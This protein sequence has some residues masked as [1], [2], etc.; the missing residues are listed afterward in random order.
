MTSTWPPW[1][2]WGAVDT[3]E[4]VTDS[5]GLCF[6]HYLRDPGNTLQPMLTLPAW[7]QEELRGTTHNH[8]H[9]NGGKQENEGLDVII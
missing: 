4:A 8:T 2:P 1:M 9:K 3:V 7:L 6:F 5:P